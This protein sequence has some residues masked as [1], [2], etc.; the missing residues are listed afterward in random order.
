MSPTSKILNW[1]VC[2]QDLKRHFVQCLRKQNS[3]GTTSKR[4]CFLVWAYK[5]KISKRYLKQSKLLGLKCLVSL[6]PKFTERK[7]E[8]V[9]KEP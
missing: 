7:G 6:F 2:F 3:R 9:C 1:C 8:E 5:H 4:K